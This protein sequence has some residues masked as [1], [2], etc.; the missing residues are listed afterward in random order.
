MSA[1]PHAGG[2]QS[3]SCVVAERLSSSSGCLVLWPVSDESCASDSEPA[4]D[5][6]YKRSPG[7]WKDAS[8]GESSS[9]R[10]FV[11]RRDNSGILEVATT[12]AGCAGSVISGSTASNER[13]GSSASSRHMVRGRARH[14]CA[15]CGVRHRG[16]PLALGACAPSMRARRSRAS[17]PTIPAVPTAR[18]GRVV[19]CGAPLP[20]ATT[21]RAHK[22]R[23]RRTRR[24]CSRTHH[25]REITRRSLS[26]RDFHPFQLGGY[27]LEQACGR[28]LAT[29]S[30][31]VQHNVAAHVAQLAR[32]RLW[33]A[34]I[35]FSYSVAA[36]Q[37]GTQPSIQPEMGRTT[38]DQR[39]W[40]SSWAER[41][42]P[43]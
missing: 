33:F 43:C 42:R 28:R 32:V 40:S 7:D 16:A 6:S 1:P 41:A 37:I 8:A 18:P 2:R 15:A 39:A 10:L 21:F 35:Y 12:D 14:G 36:T 19:C 24:V 30:V 11:R 25:L 3:V 29:R 20:L 9:S 22:S 31:L 17:I 26:D 27:T 13:N 38:S 5:S 23:R 4:G 34:G